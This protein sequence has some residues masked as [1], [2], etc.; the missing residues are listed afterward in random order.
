VVLCF[1]QKLGDISP[2]IEN[3]WS[4]V[5]FLLMKI[6]EMIFIVFFIAEHEDSILSF[7]RRLVVLCFLQK[8]GDI[9]LSIENIWSRVVFLLMKIG[10][11][12]FFV[13]FIAAID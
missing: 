4:R 6:G 1:L 5:V 11:M 9:S 8:L 7:Y 3:I 13:F 12:I 2:S 10:E